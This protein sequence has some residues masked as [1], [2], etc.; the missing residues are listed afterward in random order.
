MPRKQ[1]HDDM[2]HNLIQAYEDYL[3]H[4]DKEHAKFREESY[5]GES[6]F[7]ASST[8][9]CMKKHWY[10][11]NDAPRIPLDA[12]KLKIFRLGSVM[13]EDFKYATRH[14]IKNAS[15]SLLVY[16]DVPLVHKQLRVKVMIE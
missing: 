9:M 15:E 14:Y 2:K 6:N 13:D 4:K 16:E 8:G 11:I 10:A 7:T 3:V 1:E 5:K 12:A